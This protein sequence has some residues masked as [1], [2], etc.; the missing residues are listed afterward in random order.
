MAMLF[1]EATTSAPGIG[2]TLVPTALEHRRVDGHCAY[3]R[4]TRSPSLWEGGFVVTGPP[5]E[6]H[7]TEVRPMALICLMADLSPTAGDSVRPDGTHYPPKEIPVVFVS[8]WPK[9][10]PVQVFPRTYCL[11]CH[12]SSEATR[13]L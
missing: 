8:E 4:T 6:L 3:I 11:R 2:K 7:R 5:G 12:R 13:R 9:A 10:L 1:V